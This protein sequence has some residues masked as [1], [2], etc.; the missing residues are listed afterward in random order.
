VA[1]LAAYLSAVADAQS[2]EAEE[3]LRRMKA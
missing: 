2:R 1:R 3:G